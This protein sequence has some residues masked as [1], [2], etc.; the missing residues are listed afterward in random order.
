[1]F[2]SGLSGQPAG[3]SAAVWW[4]ASGNAVEMNFNPSMPLPDSVPLT[5]PVANTGAEADMI[6]V[7]SAADSVSDGGLWQLEDSMGARIGL[8]TQRILGEGGSLR[9]LPFG[10]P[11]YSKKTGTFSSRYTF[12]GKERDAESGLNYFGARYYNSDLSI[13]ISVDPMVDKYPSTSPYAYCRN[14]PIILVDPNGLFYDGYQDGNGNYQWFDDHHETS[15][16]ENGTTWNRVTGNKKDWDEATTIRNAV[17]EGLVSLG[18]NSDEVQ[19][20]VSLYSE[21]SNL[22]TKEANL[23]NH[24]KYTNNWDQSYNS[25]TRK[26]M[27]SYQV[28]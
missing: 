8:T 15:F 17:I 16:T 2:A 28:K 18:H 14:N 12:S 7:Y 5:F 1:M 22:F 25:D 19:K 9:Y 10:E 11:L 26:K 24:K 6:V 13:W 3:D 27:L 23:N 20:D 4:R 21:S